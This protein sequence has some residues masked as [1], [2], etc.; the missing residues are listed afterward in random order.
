MKEDEAYCII[1]QHIFS[2][3]LERM[4]EFTYYIT[5]GSFSNDNQEHLYNQEIPELNEMKLK[6][7]VLRSAKLLADMEEDSEEYD[8]LFDELR[9]LL[10]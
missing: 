4:R 10:Y 5:E 9:V 7:D 2:E 3:E 1:V 8:A 6:I